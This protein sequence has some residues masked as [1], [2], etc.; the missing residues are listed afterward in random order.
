M[1]KEEKKDIIKTLEP[2]VD[3]LNNNLN[4]LRDGINEIYAEWKKVEESIDKLHKE[5]PKKNLEAMNAIAGKELYPIMNVLA[6]LDKH[7]ADMKH[8]NS[9]NILA[10]CSRILWILNKGE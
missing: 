1:A 10:S 2:L 5:D 9:N 3:K 7:L 6:G 8:N 4:S